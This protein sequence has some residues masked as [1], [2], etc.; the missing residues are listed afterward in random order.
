MHRKVWR[1][2]IYSDAIGLILCRCGNLLAIIVTV[3]V[4]DV[5]VDRDDDAVV[6]VGKINTCI[7]LCFRL[8]YVILIGYDNSYI[9]FAIAKIVH[10][11]F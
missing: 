7:M 1:Y 8:C 10:Q 6:L 2:C 9:M 11:E 3:T 5:D 4:I